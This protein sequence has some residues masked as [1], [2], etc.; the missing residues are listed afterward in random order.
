[1][2][3]MDRQTT[4]LGILWLT[5]PAVGCPCL[6]HLRSGKLEHKPKHRPPFTL[7]SKYD[8]V[9]FILK[10]LLFFFYLVVMH[11]LVATNH[12]LMLFIVK[13]I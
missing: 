2:L 3:G 10:R 7:C 11:L 12:N 5:G 8:C 13:K 4:D 6:V 1:M 9:A